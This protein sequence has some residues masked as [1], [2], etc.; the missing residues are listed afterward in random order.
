[1]VAQYYN[2]ADFYLNFI[3][4][5]FSGVVECFQAVSP[6]AFLCAAVPVS[7]AALCRASPLAAV[8]RIIRSR[9]AYLSVRA[10]IPPRTG[11]GK[12][13]HPICGIH[14]IAL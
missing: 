10:L 1:M 13:F 11:I 12:Q 5:P 8:A 7:P 4:R 14:P 9:S 2:L 6:A 3:P